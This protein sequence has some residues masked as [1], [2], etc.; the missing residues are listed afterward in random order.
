M[1][2]NVFKIEN[3]SS[4]CAECPASN[5][6]SKLIKPINKTMVADQDNFYVY[7]IMAFSV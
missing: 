2:I 5:A 1:D 6:I 3:K 4:P 7:L